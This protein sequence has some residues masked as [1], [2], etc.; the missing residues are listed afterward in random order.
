MTAQTQ[1]GVTLIEML[2]VVAIIG[3]IASISFPALTS[4]LAGVRLSSAS[5]EVASFLTS[6]MNTVERR[7]QAAAIVI[8]PKENRMDLFTAASGEHPDKT[9]RPPASVTFE[10]DE[11]HRYMLF[12]GGAFP[13]ISVVLRNEKGSRRSVEIDPVT[14]VP[15]VRR[16]AETQP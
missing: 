1:R 4:G 9:Y 6:S 10:G 7:E 5:G 8:T 3:V 2:I 12:P 11:P 13:R 14:A 16:L 15:Q